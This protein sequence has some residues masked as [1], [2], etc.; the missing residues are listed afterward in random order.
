MVF[1]RKY[2]PQKIEDLDSTS[3]R[4][5]LAAILTTKKTSV[6]TKAKTTNKSIAPTIDSSLPHA[7]LFTG[8]KGLGKTSTAR[9]I[10]KIVN[11][12]MPESKRTNGYEPCNICE[13][14]ISITN[15]TNMDILEID[16]ASNRGIDEIRDLKDKIRLAPL[17]GKKKVYIIDEVH[18]L[19]TEA[20]NALLKTLEEPPTHALFILCTT[21]PHKIPS[22]ILSRCFHISFRLATPEELVRSFRRIVNREHIDID[23]KALLGIANLSEGGFR[24]GT[25]ILEE[26]F[27]LSN[28]QKIT[29]E[30]VEEKYRVTSITYYLHEFFESFAKR[31]AKKGIQMIGKLVDQGIDI[32][33]FVQQL[34][35]E[36]HTLLLIQMGIKKNQESSLSPELKSRGIKNQEFAMEE[37]K[38]FYELLANTY[39]DMKYAILPQLPLELA[40][41]EW[42][43]QKEITTESELRTE[44]TISG[45]NDVTLASLRKKAGNISKIKALYGDSSGLKT[46]DIVIA[47]TEGMELFD[48]TVDGEI[49]KDWMNAFWRSIISEV[50]KYN[51]TIAGVLRG[52]MIKSYD[53]K[54]LI[55]QTAYKFHKERLDDIK[56]KEILIKICKQLTGKDI[57]VTIELKK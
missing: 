15:G 33:Y 56:T 5:T 2:R 9:I 45:E 43:S 51:H 31:D 25:K 3:V 7:F 46:K 26:L 57:G 13:Q 19:T 36:L 11:C 23:E 48:F 39:S 18:M 12:T 44:D 55:I 30:L 16:A 34:I 40:L 50:R 1:Y 28:G 22:T 21:E 32:K 6:S 54:S 29:P 14:C 27:S 41:I 53:R 42:C 8:P 4:E 52:C 17:S 24:D 20:F 10:A 47:T 49:T 35:I 37:I 38:S